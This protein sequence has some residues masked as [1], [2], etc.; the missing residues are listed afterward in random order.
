[1]DQFYT[2]KLILVSSKPTYLSRLPSKRILKFNFWAKPAVND[3]KNWGLKQIFVIKEAD[4]WIFINK[5]TVADTLVKAE[6]YFT[7]AVRC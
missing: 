7:A 1:M 4:N 5:K 3:E 6:V 2:T